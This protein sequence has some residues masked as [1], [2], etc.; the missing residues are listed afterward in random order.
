MYKFDWISIN[1]YLE[2]IAAVTLKHLDTRKPE[3]DLTCH[4][5]WKDGGKEATLI[6]IVCEVYT[7]ILL[8]KY[9]G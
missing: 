1:Q 8:R 5:N 3:V 7:N 9:H 4:I 2:A 6:C